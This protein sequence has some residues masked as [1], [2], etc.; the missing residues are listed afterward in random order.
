MFL[1]SFVSGKNILLDI[2]RGVFFTAHKGRLLNRNT[3]SGGFFDSGRAFYSTR[4]LFI[5]NDNV[6]R[7]AL[8]FQETTKQINSKL[9]GG[10]IQLLF[11]NQSF[12]FGCVTPW[13][14]PSQRNKS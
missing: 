12:T 13:K 6:A 10:R 3:P 4:K 14:N 8:D 7:S 1:F 11:Q 2:S 5:R 9:R